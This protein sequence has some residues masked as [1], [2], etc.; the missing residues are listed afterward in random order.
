MTVALLLAPGP[1]PAQ[2]DTHTV[3]SLEFDDGWQDATV[4]A[5]S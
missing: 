2:A 3:V 5:R 1:S 4:A